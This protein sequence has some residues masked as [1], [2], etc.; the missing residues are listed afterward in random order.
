M[1][2][3]YFYLMAALALMAGCAKESL[4]SQ[5]ELSG[6]K[7]Y[8]TVGLP[9]DSKTHMGDSEAGARPV[10]WSN[11]DQIAV[12]GKASD[13]LSGLADD[14]TSTQFSFTEVV[15]HLPYKVV[16]PA[17]ITTEAD[18][19]HV[20]LPAVQTYRAGGFAEGMNPMAGYT[21]DGNNVSMSH[22]CA[23]VKISVKRAATGIVDEDN[24][25]AVRF[26]GRNNEKVSGDFEINYATATLATATGTGSDL[27]VRVVKNQA[28]STTTAIDYYLV[29]PAR[30]YANGFD[31]IVQDVNGHIMTKSKTSSKA[32][33]AG[34]L[35][36]MPEFEFVPTETELGVEISS[37]EQLIAFATAYNNKEYGA[38]LVATVTA[39]ITFDA[40]S[41]AAFNA[42]GGIGTPY[43]GD[44]YFNG[45]FN[46]N[47]HTISGLKA[48]VPLFAGMDKGLVKDLTLDNSCSFA[49]T[50]T[51]EADEAMFASIV[52]YHKGVLDNVKVAADIE[53]EA[54]A[55]IT[56]MT[57]IGGLTGRTTVGKLQN[58]C[59]YSGLISTPAGF[60]TTG[61]LIIGGLVGRFSNAG[62]VTDSYFKGAISN[63]AQVSSTDTNNPYL[64]IGGVVGHVDGDATVSSTNSTADH[65]AQ[66][67][68]HSTM[69]GIIV[70]KTTVAYNS[71]VGG[72]VG[73][74][75][76]GTVSDCANAASIALTIFKPG[77]TSA[78]YMKTGGIVGKVN[79]NGTI[80][81]CTNNGTV[82]H[83]SN[84]RLQDIG[85]IAG[86]NAGT[87]TSCTNTVAVNHMTTGVSGA[88]NKG[89]RIVNLAGII[90][91]NA[92]GATVSDVHNTGAL[93]ISAMEDNYDTE[94]DKPICEV[95]MGGVIA[96]NLAD[97][98]GGATKNITNSGQV[99]L[100]TTPSNPFIGFELGG[101]VGYSVASIKNVANSGQVV[102]T[103]NQA[104]AVTRLYMG[105]VV[106]EVANTANVE[107]S[108]CENSGVVYFNVNSK[109]AAHT[110]DFL[111][112]LVGYIHSDDD[113]TATISDNENSGYVH[114]ACTSTIACSNLIIGGVIGKMA[115]SGTV[116][117]CNNVGG[118]NNTGEIALSF[119][120]AVHTDN[121]IGGIL[122]KTESDVS[123]TSCN[124]SG[125]VQGGN[126]TAHNGATC[127][128]GGIVAY[129]AGASSLSDCGNSGVVY[130][131]QRN[132]T[133]TNVGS[134][135]NGGIAGYIRGTST[136]YISVVGCDNTASNMFSRRGWLG[137]IVA[138]A[139]YANLENC[140]FDQDVTLSC[141]CRGIGGIVG[142][143][144]NTNV[145]SCDYTGAE[146]SA[147]Q[148]QANRAG[149]IL[150]RL[151]GGI[152]DSCNSSVGTFM[153]H[154]SSA[155]VPVAGGAIVGISGSGNTIQNCHYKPT[156]NSAA[157]NIAG[158]GSFTDGGGNVADL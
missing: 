58:G 83:R 35:Y 127:F 64:I 133:D 20:T 96:Y 95:R 116:S 87:V 97:I 12:N 19:D 30:T 110:G 25:V 8:L 128:T 109:A 3:R 117:D 123:L 66:A 36:N 67:T 13:E 21:T 104:Y 15:L 80:T 84:P 38:D 65:A 136:D 5:N 57:T 101:I 153:S 158:T 79:A 55:D 149:G 155:D 90:G 74:L 81:N 24:I 47:N 29:V 114:I 156:I 56:Q 9:S 77:N 69:T 130:N 88:T 51:N 62:N 89:G 2:T 85:G 146:L 139:E 100:T 144:A 39:D 106:G 147:T 52:G 11:G 76:K 44:N 53:I 134:T 111:G 75:N 93:Q 23:I 27:E 63:A 98:D 142:W 26:K 68:A 6:E 18:P 94:G 119:S 113:L 14:V 102:N 59:E 152:V 92:S 70:N 91:E 41:S 154:P 122:G 71:A 4:E 145:T 115:E 17:S 150:G 135:Y 50:H 34:H 125:Y 143:G 40:T 132:N 10:Y 120:D 126:S 28:T 131:N 42:T 33:E 118:N 37:A 157:S 141:L 138:Y 112:G 7:F 54:V 151:D 1:K 22:L 31:V 16:Y 129:L 99:A 49:F 82:Q 43:G 86:Y 78:R 46:G 107:I 72:I 140:T 48:T 61:K 124:N 45:V 137:G 73:E 105:G 108:G 148:I 32:L 121:Y 103:L 60:T